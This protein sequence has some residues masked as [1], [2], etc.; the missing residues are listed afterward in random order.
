[1]KVG[2]S[3]KQI[4]NSCKF[5]YFLILYIL[6]CYMKFKKEHIYYKA[7]KYMGIPY[8]IR[9]RMVQIRK[10]RFSVCA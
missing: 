9:N 10:T 4:N 8:T 7:H 1:M 3:E 2:A 6:Y 5:K